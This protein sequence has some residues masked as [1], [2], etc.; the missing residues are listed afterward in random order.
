VNFGA[1]IAVGFW[2]CVV[3]LIIYGLTWDARRLRENRRRRHKW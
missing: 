2:A 3:L 1:V